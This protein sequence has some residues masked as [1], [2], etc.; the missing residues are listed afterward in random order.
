[1]MQATKMLLGKPVSQELAR[2]GL[3]PFALRG[4]AP[5]DGGGSERHTCQRKWHEKL[6]L[7]PQ[8]RNIATLERVKKIAIPNIQLVLD[9]QLGNSKKY[10]E[11]GQGPGQ[12]SPFPRPK[13]G[14]RVPEARG[15]T[16]LCN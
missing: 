13:G 6:G 12:P 15:Q 3:A 10:Q 9:Q 7:S 16:F 2:R 5:P 4:H 8:P 11:R 1:M 14:G